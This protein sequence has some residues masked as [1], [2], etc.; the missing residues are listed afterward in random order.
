MSKFNTECP[1]CGGTKL[2]RQSG[3][4][5]LAIA[6]IVT[7]SVAITILVFLFWLIFTIP[8]AAI[9]GVVGLLMLI[10]SPFATKMWMYKCVECKASWWEF[11]DEEKQAKIV[12]K[13]A[14]KKEA[15]RLKRANKTK[16]KL[17][18]KDTEPI[19]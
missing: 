16:V 13:R 8:M 9:I 15:K 12:E 19:L 6:G 17:V 2:T 14:A 11:K 18:K 5:V 3:G 10:G 4:G 1:K 7:M